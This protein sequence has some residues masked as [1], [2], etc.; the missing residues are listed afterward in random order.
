[1]NLFAI[2]DHA[3]W[4]HNVADPTTIN[5]Q[6][7][8]LVNI[9][10]SDAQRK[11]NFEMCRVTASLAIDGTTGG[12]LDDAV[13]DAD[14]LTSVAVTGTLSPDLTG[15]YSRT[16]NWNGQPLLVRASNPAAYVFYSSFY[17]NWILSPT[18]TN[19][20]LPA[21][22]TPSAIQSLYT[23]T[24]PH[25]GTAT[26][27]ATV[28]TSSAS[29]WARL[30]EVVAIL[31]TNLNGTHVPLDFTRDDIPIERD[32]TVR[33]LSD[34]FWPW[35]RFPSDADILNVRGNAA[36]TQRRRSLFVYPSPTEVVSQT[37]L[38]VILYGFGWLNPY[39]ATGLVGDAEQDFLCIYGSDY[40]LWHVVDSLNLKYK[41]FVPRTEGNLVSP[42]DKRDEAWKE[43]VL[44]DSYMVDSNSNRSR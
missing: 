17:T 12:S 29:Q 33:E 6:F 35:N 5:T 41:T 30:K 23:G 26:G 27:T 8:R 32:R 43:L 31:R 24:Y 36:I 38:N 42:T 44:W 3:A 18:L 1:M 4:L 34:N 15:T 19:A 11:H 28:A 7:L 25:Q 39:A 2:R 40:L 37:P 9:A 10:Q 14:A 16:G 13:I 21:Y 22:F 20:S